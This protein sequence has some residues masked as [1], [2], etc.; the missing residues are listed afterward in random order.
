MKGMGTG[1]VYCVD[2]GIFD[3]LRYLNRGRLRLAVISKKEL[4]PD[5]REAV[6]RMLNDPGAT[7]VA[8][9]KEFENF[10]GTNER[11]LKFADAAGYR[12]DMLV[13]IPDSFGRPAIEV[14]RFEAPDNDAGK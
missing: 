9:T 6:L 11:L 10:P 13:V 8:H 12:R 5:D 7:F 1:T 4:T 14:Y 2:W 3:P